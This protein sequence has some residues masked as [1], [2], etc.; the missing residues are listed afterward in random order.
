MKTRIGLFALASGIASAAGAASPTPALP[1]GNYAGQRALVVV[2]DPTS[3]GGDGVA[4]NIHPTT[5]RYDAASQSYVLYDYEGAPGTTFA[6]S[7][8]VASHSS[9]RTCRVRSRRSTCSGSSTRPRSL[10]RL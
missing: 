1:T 7:E 4:A 9:P 10:S 5:V 8:K 2:A 3:Y 6:P